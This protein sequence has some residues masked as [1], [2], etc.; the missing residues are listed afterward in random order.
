MKISVMKGNSNTSQISYRSFPDSVL[1]LDIT[2][3]S[4]QSQSLYF[5]HR[6]EALAPE[7]KKQLLKEHR[8]IRN[9]YTSLGL[10]SKSQLPLKSK[11]SDFRWI[12]SSDKSSCVY[13][14]LISVNTPET[15]IKRFQRRLQGKVAQVIQKED[16]FKDSWTQ[17]KFN[18][19][20]DGFNDAI[21]KQHFS[22]FLSSSEFEATAMSVDKSK[23]DVEEQIE[24]Y[25]PVDCKDN[26]KVNKFRGKFKLGTLKLAFVIMVGLFLI[27]CMLH[28]FTG[29][30]RSYHLKKKIGHK[31]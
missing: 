15:F 4:D 13:I 10:D 9:K 3:V 27:F 17:E 6:L 30:E 29:P 7:N 31:I 2:R 23:R 5:Q 21:K 22:E 12:V 8:V 1:L 19:L 14:L 16:D 28:R 20:V 18:E 26:E 11:V 24:N 25:E